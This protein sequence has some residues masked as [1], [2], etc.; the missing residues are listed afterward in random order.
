[1]IGSL[2]SDA[3]LRAL[4]RPS[5]LPPMPANPSTDLLHA[6]PPRVSPAPAPPPGVDY[7]RKWYVMASVAMGVFLATADGSI[8][9]VAL[10]TLIQ[11][12]NTTFATV[13]WVVLA[14][15]LT[16]ATLLLSVGRLADMRG[17]RPIYVAGFL[18]FTLGSVLCGLAPTVEWLIALRVLQ[19]IGAA[20]VMALGSAILTEAFPP[21]ERGK[22]L[23]TSGAVVSIG[24]ITGPTLGG[25]ILGSFSWHWIF[26]VNLPIGL[27]GS[28]M[29]W[30]SVP[31]VRP[32]HG[33][34][35]D[36]AGASVFF[37]GLLSLLLALTFGQS[38]GYGNARVLTLFGLA[39]VALV[40]FLLIEA[41]VAQPMMALSL[42]RNRT[43][44]LNLAT[45]LLL[46]M[47]LA[48]ATFLLPFYLQNIRGL[49]VRQVG[50][51]L[52]ATPIALGITSPIS[53]ALSD[54][55]GS[56]RISVAGLLIVVL[57][58]VG[59][60]SLRADTPLWAYVLRMLPLGVGMGMF[61]SP[62]NSAIMGSVPRERLG[63]A[64]GLLAITRTIGQ[65]TG[66]ALFGAFWAGRVAALLG[67]LPDGGATLAPTAEQV[68]GLQ[69]TFVAIALMV[70]VAL[71]LG[72]GALVQE[73][74]RK[75]R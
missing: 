66:I 18:V 41:R 23:G 57:A 2:P 8:V 17:K 7:S 25:L 33:Q 3:T 34:T 71:A 65:T 10:P 20:M 72:V 9:N 22:A 49:D 50:L 30:R 73:E 47:G 58:Y 37:V 36:Y 51:L 63:I 31:Q 1:M 15:L 5:P 67:G 21:N 6:G 16:V 48:G 32:R 42:F 74:R 56:R 54:R 39:A 68:T 26:F 46:F 75:R 40:A 60:W 14:Y 24:I 43:F 59:L 29:A 13:Q 52:A 44:S 69:Q 38:A 55:F 61:Q 19:G 28:W 12:L 45:G 53:G 27:L 35:F 64:S 4:L 11:E 62:N 70:G